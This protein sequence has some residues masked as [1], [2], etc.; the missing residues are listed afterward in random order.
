MA[1]T[2]EIIPFD[3][4]PGAH[5]STVI[6]SLP[7]GGIILTDSIVKDGANGTGNSLV[8]TLRSFSDA[9]G[10]LSKTQSASSSSPCN[11]ESLR[12]PV[13][14]LTVTETTTSFANWTRRRDLLKFRKVMLP[15]NV[16]A[17]GLLEEGSDEFRQRAEADEG[18]VYVG[19]EFFLGGGNSTG[20]LSF[21]VRPDCLCGV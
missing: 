14:F 5:N 7:S 1:L 12:R 13:L 11:C 19:A 10:P 2:T 21:H 17:L 3:E 9:N 4:Y 18:I 8:V 15:N 20:H 6:A 16:A